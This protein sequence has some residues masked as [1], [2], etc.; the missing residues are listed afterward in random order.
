MLEPG[1]KLMV[2]SC[3]YHVSLNM[4][5]EAIRFASN[6]IGKKLRVIDVT[7][8]PEDHPWILQMPE[9]LYLKTIYLEVLK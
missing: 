7:F 9:T 3:A 8:Q 4:L 1:G 5:K 6:D 2:S